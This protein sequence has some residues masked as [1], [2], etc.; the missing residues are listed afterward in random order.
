[1]DDAMDEDTVSLPHQQSFSS[2]KSDSDYTYQVNYTPYLY[3]P[4]LLNSGLP[5]LKFNSL[6]GRSRVH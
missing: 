2:L 4:P 3:Q 1:M 6:P 5:S